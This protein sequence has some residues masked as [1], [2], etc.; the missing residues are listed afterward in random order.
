MFR[1]LGLAALVGV[2]VLVG[3]DLLLPF[4]GAVAPAGVCDDGSARIVVDASDQVLVLCAPGHPAEAFHVRLGRAGIDK[5]AEGDRRTPSGAYA[6]DAPRPSNSGFHTFIPVGY[7][8]D[9]QRAA[10]YTGS[11][12][13]IHGPPWLVRVPL[14]SSL[15]QWAMQAHRPNTSAGCIG[16]DRVD[17]IEEIAAWVRAHPD[18]PVVIVE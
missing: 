1:R 2:F 6:L 11:A 14:R 18:A 5:R 16:L 3:V 15:L 17:E 7:P 4:P 12:I 13:G 8:T 9:T 10:G